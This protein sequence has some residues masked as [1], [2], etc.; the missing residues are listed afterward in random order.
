MSTT[1]KVEN[2]NAADLMEEGTVIFRIYLK[3]SIIS[4]NIGH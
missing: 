2:V 1:L 4:D 3:N